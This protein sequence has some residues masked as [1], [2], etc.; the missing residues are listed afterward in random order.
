MIQ[1]VPAILTKNK[2]ELDKKIKQAEKLVDRVQI[3]IMD[4]KF[5]PNITIKA[6]DLKKNPNLFIEAHLMIVK[7]EKQIAQFAKVADLI[8][9]HFEV[10]KSLKKLKEIIRKIKN[11]DLKAG[12]AL[13]P[14]TP[15]AK[16]KGILDEVDLV[17]L[18]TVRPGFGGQ[19]FMLEVLP[20][21]KELRSL[22]KGIDIEIDG[23]IKVG[24]AKK[25]AEAGANLLVAG[26]S[27]FKGE[28]EKNIKALKEDVKFVIST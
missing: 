16:I 18:M 23:G 12:V 19:E 24:T 20:K 9:V 26:T 21:I 13:N 25:A 17:L 4:G 22:A 10:C 8:I 1:I 7:P 6:S 27:V 5:V 3:D 15:L 11:Y 2:T 14:E 28:V